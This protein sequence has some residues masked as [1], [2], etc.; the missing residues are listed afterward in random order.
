MGKIVKSV[1]LVGVAVAAVV[2]A[3]AIAGFVAGALKGVGLTLAA[4]TVAGIKT[5]IILTGLSVGMN[6][7][8]GAFRKAPT[9]PS[10][11]VERLQAS[12]IATAPR[13]IVFGRTAAGNDIRFQEQFRGSGFA[14]SLGD[15]SAQVIA[16]ASHRI[17]A[18]KEWRVD[19]EVVWNGS[20]QKYQQGILTFQAVTEG[21]RA[22]AHKV[23]SGAY[24]NA[25]DSSFTGCAYLSMTYRLKA[26]LWPQGLPRNTV[27]VVEGCPLYDPR[28]DS[29]QGGSG[30]H[31][32]NDQSTWR[33]FEGATEIG[34]NP[35]LQLLTYLIGY[36]INGHLVWGM[37]VPLDRIDLTNFAL[38]ANLCEEGVQLK[39]GGSIPRYQSDG[40]YSTN[41]THQAV[42]DA[43]TAA[44]G[45]CKLTDAGGLYGLLGGYDDTLGQ[46]VSLSDEDI[47]APEGSPSPYSWVPAPPARESYNAIRGRYA[48][49]AQGFQLVDW[50][51]VSVAPLADGVPR[52]LN[53]DFPTV[54]RFEACQRIARQFLLRETLTPGVFAATFGPAA[55]AAQVGSLVRL[56]IRG[57]G[58]NSK[59]FRVLDQAQS[60]GM[61]F[62]MTLREES[63]EV[64]AWDR[65][66]TDKPLNVAVPAYD[67]RAVEAPSGLTLASVAVPGANG[68]SVAVV[69]A[70]W[71]PDVSG[72][73]GGVV[74]QSRVVGSDIWTE[75][76]SSFDPTIGRFRFTSTVNGANL[77][78]RLRNR[79]TT[80]LVSDW[81]SATVQ[82][83]EV[84]IVYEDIK[85]TPTSIGDINQEE[86][87]K[88]TGIEPGATVGGVI[89]RDIYLPN[90]E[91]F[92]PG[93]G[94]GGTVV[95]PT[96][97]AIPT[98]LVLTPTLT[99]AG[100]D[101]TAAW[102]APADTD[103]AGYVLEIAEGAGSTNFFPVTVSGTAY[104][105]TALARNQTYR[106]RVRAFDTSFNRS[107][108]SA[109]SDVQTGR[110]TQPPQPPAL[111]TATPA[112]ES[113]HVQ[114][115]NQD[116]ED[117]DSVRVELQ[118]ASNDYINALTVKAIPNREGS[119]FFTSL[120]KS[121][122][123]RVVATAFDTSG[124]ES[125]SSNVLTFATAGGID[126]DDLTPNAKPFQTVDTLPNPVGYG[127]ALT[128]MNKAD[129]KLYRYTGGAWTKAVDGADLTPNSVTTNSVATGAIGTAQLA[130][131]A[132]TIGKLAIGNFDNVI[133]DGSFND[134]QWWTGN[135]P[136]SEL[137][138]TNANW[139]DFRRG[140]NFTN[141]NFVGLFTPLFVMEPGARYRVKVSTFV[142]SDFSG[143]FTPSLHLPG[144]SWLSLKSFGGADGNDPAQPGSHAWTQGNYSGGNVHTAEFPVFNV[145][146][147]QG[148]SAQFR[149]DA[150]FT[151]VVQIAI[152]LTR[153]A[154]ATLIGDGEITT[155]KMVVGSIN[156]DRLSVNSM[157]GNVLK[158]T[159]ALAD[160]ITVGAGQ[161][162]GSVRDTAANTS[163]VT[164]KAGSHPSV[165][166]VG[167]SLEQT[168]PTGWS[169]T[170]YA[171][172]K[173]S[174]TGG[175]IVSG[176][177]SRRMGFI[178]LADPAVA[179]NE[180][181]GTNYQ[182]MNSMWH[183]SN[184]ANGYM[185]GW[186][187]W[188]QILPYGYTRGWNAD[189]LFS[190]EYEGRFKVWRADGVEVHRVAWAA[191]QTFHGKFCVEDGGKISNIGFTSA[192]DNSL[193]QT[194]P[195]QRI[196]A[197]T[198]LIE[199]GRI[200]I[201]GSTT[202]SS[203]F[204]GPDSTE[205]NGGVIATNT[206]RA[207]SMTIG[208]RQV[209][210]VGCDFRYDRTNG[211][212]YWS[213]GHVLYADD[214][215]GAASRDIPA[216]STA[217]LG[218]SYNYVFWTKDASFF[219]AGADN[220]QGAHTGVADRIIMCIWRNGALFTAYYG[221]T[222]L[223]GERIATNTLNADRIIGGSIIA[224]NVIIGG[225]YGTLGNVAATA[226]TAK[227]NADSALL[228]LTNIVSDNVLSRAEKQALVNDWN[229]LASASNSAAQA[230]AQFGLDGFDDLTYTQRVARDGAHAA[231]YDY[232]NSLTPAYNNMTA[233]TPVNGAYLRQV[234]QT[235]Y[236]R[237]EE[238]VAANTSAASRVT[239]T[240]AGVAAA[241]V[242]DNA[243]AGAAAAI[244]VTAIINDNMISRAEK[245]QMIRDYT[246]IERASTAAQQASIAFSTN[247]F[248]DPTLSARQARDTATTALQNYLTSLSPQW[249]NVNVDTPVDG[250]YLRQLFYNVQTA[251]ENLITANN[252]AASVRSTWG[253]TIGAG[254]PQDNATVGAP[255]GT[256]VN[257][258]LSQTVESWASTGAQDPATRI[259]SG[260]TTI[261]GGRITTGS[262][263]ASRIGVANLSAIS[264]N[265]GEVTAGVLRNS[266]GSS[267]IDLAAGRITFNNGSVMKVSGIGFGSANQF[268]EWFGPSQSNL[269]ACTEAN[270]SFY[271]K[272]D[273]SSYFGGSL[274][275][276]V[277]RNAATTTATANN[278]S[279]STGNVGSN[280][281]TRTVVISYTWSE[282]YSFYQAQE[283]G[284]GTI[285]AQV[286]LRRN[287]ANVA[288]L[289]V[290]GS[291]NRSPGY[292]SSEPGSY[293]ENMGGSLT[294]TD[295][296]GG[297]AVEYSAHLI[298]RSNG[299][300]GA[301][302]SPQPAS[303]SQALGII[304][305]EG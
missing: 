81:V 142:S 115:T 31:R 123:Y 99:E 180:A 268:I 165:R 192:N 164:L 55:F 12:T 86:G 117:L 65:H 203:I 251:V 205:I 186:N 187:G 281:G 11:A 162:I 156:A 62:A 217:W 182:S 69:D 152:S 190:I 210:V 46:V 243:A 38:Y 18:V 255:A 176:R 294:F 147:A 32:H 94:G 83:A 27:T 303:Q 288:T 161:T 305:T 15:L 291:W 56:S 25:P 124:N 277:I 61:F 231:V 201:T 104:K 269:S 242:K 72:K 300:G 225:G 191:D 153:I 256:Y 84:E 235:L 168:A 200:R 16:L 185:L 262:I 259:N 150:A 206:L 134:L 68:I 54:S 207:N 119:L 292:G 82:T 298:S 59:L 253:N 2:F 10:A 24:W 175:A 215:G 236:A 173:E 299:P 202:L 257:G 89:G 139:K 271:L 135:H 179:F 97:P 143:Y 71:T 103:V 296:T 289:N 109:I 239:A 144:V 128:V 181:T 302:A 151:G 76:A 174:Y 70:T 266:S 267:R 212:L 101:L 111:H 100:A 88:L 169:V 3:P 35:A 63:S 17:Q 33:W 118:N 183:L 44:M 218:G 171:T 91:I 194:D 197:H 77:E 80:G 136:S 127:G 122:G 53:L 222:I 45:S 21:S 148:K 297:A 141:G 106:V 57:Q 129:G 295:N 78:V 301:G 264:A 198:T 34:R 9:M 90:G 73:V 248:G 96:P 293:S 270:A 98:G 155:P 274:R 250:P 30:S 223:D 120:A 133:P 7:V 228:S 272:I 229:A 193:S 42:I 146:H 29:T 245:H 196:N 227:D 138:E 40:I 246:A 48:D 95:D 8:L 172:T 112:Y 140:L 66:E 116:D 287:G 234:F 157:D 237:V 113:V 304:Q 6:A 166:I 36:R 126:A 110:D 204:A 121:T 167:N 211:R 285:S 130:A 216:G 14:S 208:N 241:T 74:I 92:V 125:A 214:A 163:V 5:A 260:S 49:P 26:D 276:G 265:I 20:L 254:R 286:V 158:V 232:L 28:R 39:D 19:N 279:T 273:G 132:A 252:A 278:A 238:L 213:A 4:A 177:L 258:T 275:A 199:R 43:L 280:G 137:F 108:W 114:W 189:T 283:G 131:G 244:S 87:D 219:T 154:D 105:W 178:G 67:A 149:F 47:V 290:S 37:G 159:T 240:V 41:D 85:D 107:G 233:D 170:S 50:G 282:G 284:S 221:G 52:V 224:G 263:D 195:A 79:M 1:L 209:K 145:D 22:N 184:E 226:N 13:K 93:E 102:T 64:Y 75:H 160:T 51:E 188:S 247:G 220:W 261:S 249:D 60:A 58:W 23:G 230:S